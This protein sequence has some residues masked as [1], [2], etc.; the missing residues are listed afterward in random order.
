MTENKNKKLGC[1]EAWRLGSWETNPP[2]RF[3]YLFGISPA[4]FNLYPHNKPQKLKSSDCSVNDKAFGID[5]NLQ[6]PRLI[7]GAKCLLP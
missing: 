7:P 2:T 4:A 5:L 6:Q 1:L 3:H